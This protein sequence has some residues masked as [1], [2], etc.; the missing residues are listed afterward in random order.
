MQSRLNKKHL[1]ALVESARKWRIPSCP[2]F[3]YPEDIKREFLSI[4]YLGRW[5]EW[6]PCWALPI[7]KFSH[8]VAIVARAIGWKPVELARHIAAQAGS[9]EQSQVYQWVCDF[10]APK[11]SLCE[12]M[13]ALESWIFYDLRPQLAFVVSAYLDG[14]Q[15]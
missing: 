2:P 4:I 3:Y 13:Q 10:N 5:W 14:S 11:V 12:C 8:E 7:E 1:E 15:N 9:P 6:M